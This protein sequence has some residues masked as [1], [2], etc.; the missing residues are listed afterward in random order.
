MVSRVTLPFLPAIVLSNALLFAFYGAIW[1]GCR[2][3]RM[4]PARFDMVLAPS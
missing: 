1:T 2:T 4:L 3:L